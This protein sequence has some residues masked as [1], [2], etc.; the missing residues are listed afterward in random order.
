MRVGITQSEEDLGWGG[1]RNEFAVSLNVRL[2][3]WSSTL[4]FGLTQLI[5]LV[6]GRWVWTGN[7]LSAAG[8]LAI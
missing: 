7:A 1:R 3:L 2:E 6:L 8:S 4:S 5:L